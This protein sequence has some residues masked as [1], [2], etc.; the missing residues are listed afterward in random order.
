MLIPRWLAS[1]TALPA[2]MVC[3]FV[4]L[5]E[6]PTAIYFCVC[7]VIC[8]FC[9]AAG[10]RFFDVDK[11]D[12]KY[13][14]IFCQRMQDPTAKCS[15]CNQHTPKA[16]LLLRCKMCTSGLLLSIGSLHMLSVHSFSSGVCSIRHGL[17]A[18]AW[19]A[20]RCCLQGSS[21][22]LPRMQACCEHWRKCGLLSR[23][24]IRFVFSLLFIP[25]MKYLLAFHEKCSTMYP[26]FVSKQSTSSSDL[27]TL[28]CDKCKPLVR[29]CTNLHVFTCSVLAVLCCF[30]S[31]L[32]LAI[33]S[34][35]TIG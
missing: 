29:F 20:A 19:P 34:G 6:L 9:E 7:V 35:W 23:L 14:C 31:N 26:K 2:N 17:L 30:R 25:I 12:P 16:A 21:E 33:G 3:A 4:F 27:V 11:R 8:A 1:V 5:H 28:L 10:G 15:F 22:Y 32:E 18:G 13:I 24:S